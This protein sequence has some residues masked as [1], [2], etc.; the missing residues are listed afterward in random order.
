MTEKKQNKK[1]GI[2]P[3][4]KGFWKFSRVRQ[5]A[6]LKNLYELSP[7][8]KSLFQLRLG[9]NQD[10][11]FEA[12]KKEIQKESINRIARFRKLRLSKLNQIL[13]NAEK[14]ALPMMQQIELK[15]EV[16]SGMLSFI[17][18][19]RYL[20]ERYQIACARHLDQYLKMVQDHILETSEVEAMLKQEQ[21]KLKLII[22]RGFYLPHV[23]AVY[24]RWFVENS[25][26]S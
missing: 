19:K 15:K 12:L 13:R 9:N 2:K 17:V 24:L 7:E 6:F 25:P 14:Y 21:A 20:P 4:V 3:L 18:A 10:F 5:E 26:L 1:I 16:W 22:E 23:E 8:N 11:V